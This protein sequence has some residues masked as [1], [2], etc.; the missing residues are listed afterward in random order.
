MGKATPSTAGKRKRAA[1]TAI[2]N[3]AKSDRGK[4]NA[5]LVARAIQSFE[6]RLESDGVKATVGDFVRLLQLQKELNGAEPRE[7]K[8]TWIEP[9]ETASSEE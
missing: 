6:K 4:T 2:K 9:C 5:E 1:K 8:I 7:I 3:P